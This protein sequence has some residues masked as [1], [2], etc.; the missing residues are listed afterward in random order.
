MC[1]VER[2]VHQ[3]HKVTADHVAERFILIAEKLERI[4]GGF[5]EAD[6]RLRA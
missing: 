3:A 4:R 1:M 6:G 5:A 2:T